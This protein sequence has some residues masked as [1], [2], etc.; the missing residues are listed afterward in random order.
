MCG[1]ESNENNHMNLHVWSVKEII[2]LY[3]S[4]VIS[5]NYYNTMPST[6][7]IS[8]CPELTRIIAVAPSRG[9]FCKWHCLHTG[10]HSRDELM[11]IKVYS[12]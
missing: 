10:K 8:L 4:I 5:S 7:S 1:I 6:S 12:T 2:R 11:E 9:F 3:K